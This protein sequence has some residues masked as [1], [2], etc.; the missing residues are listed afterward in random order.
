M[1]KDWNES[2]EGALHF[3]NCKF[4][5]LCTAVN[6]RGYCQSVSDESGILQYIANAYYT[7]DLIDGNEYCFI[8]EAIDAVVMRAIFDRKKV[9]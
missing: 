8:Y 1:R 3:I 4:K 6:T 2:R 9:Q 7:A 5:E